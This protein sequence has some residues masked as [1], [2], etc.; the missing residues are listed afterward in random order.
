[1][2]KYDENNILSSIK[3]IVE[4]RYIDK[5]WKLTKIEETILSSIPIT[6]KYFAEEVSKEKKVELWPWSLSIEN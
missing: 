3:T 5:I 2:Y 6:K 1:M 4:A